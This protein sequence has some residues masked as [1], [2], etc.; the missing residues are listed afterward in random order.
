MTIT[1]NITSYPSPKS[2]IKKKKKNQKWNKRKTGKKIKE[3]ENKTKF[4][5]YNSDNIALSGD[6]VVKY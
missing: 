2:K 3:K 5:V 4:I 6:L 1:C